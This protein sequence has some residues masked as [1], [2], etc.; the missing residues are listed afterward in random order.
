MQ[1]ELNA[2]TYRLN[3]YTSE[4]IHF[5]HQIQ[6]YIMF[7]VIECLWTRML[8]D[9]EH[10]KTLD[11]ILEAHIQLLQDI[12]LAGL[13][14][15]QQKISVTLQTVWS[16]MIKLEAW[17]DKFYDICFVEL[18]ARKREQEDIKSSEAKGKYGV[19]AEKRFER[20]Q[21]HKVFRQQLVDYEKSL[22][23][24]GRDYQIAVQQ[25][26]LELAQANNHNLQLFGTR[27]DFNEY[28]KKRDYRL[29][30]PLMFVNMR[31]SSMFK[32]NKSSTRLSR[33]AANN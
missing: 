29:D 7:E 12:A 8:D 2:I 1:K 10:A 18:N 27:L 24:V 30:A 14:D 13:M 26:L 11:D 31:Q 16:A 19:T 15:D 3:L 6:Y 4:M 28:Y 25:F 33:F 21:E 23:K 9:I 22:E 20:D 17:Q 32:N 5:I